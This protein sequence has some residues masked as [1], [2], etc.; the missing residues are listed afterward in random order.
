[1]PRRL[2]QVFLVAMALA[3]GLGLLSSCDPPW[4][5]RPAPTETFVPAAEQPVHATLTTAGELIPTVTSA[6]VVPTSTSNDG[7]A[8]NGGLIHFVIPGGTCL[9]AWIIAHG[10]SFDS[11]SPIM[12]CGAPDGSGFSIGAW[13]SS[14]GYYDLRVRCLASDTDYCRGPSLEG[15]QTAELLNVPIASD[16]LEWRPW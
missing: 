9:D 13:G 14:N 6:L 16:G 10:E 4:D 1:M 3:P 7:R 2:K 12:F 8:S 15:A 5:P 11:E